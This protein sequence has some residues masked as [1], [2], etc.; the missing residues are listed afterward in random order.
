VVGR[1]IDLAAARNATLRDLVAVAPGNAASFRAVLRAGFTPLGSLQLFWFDG[2]KPLSP[3]P[4]L[5]G[6]PE[7]L[8][9]DDVTPR[10]TFRDPGRSSD[11]RAGE[12][13][14]PDELR[15]D[16]FERTV[17]ERRLE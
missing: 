13:V 10:R 9:D 11:T 16:A 12:V 15:A 7:V 17:D 14:A 4:A 8:V 5:V 1:G 2:E 6:G 3:V